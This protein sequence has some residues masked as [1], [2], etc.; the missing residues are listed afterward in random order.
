MT[1]VQLG[2][3]PPA[4]LEDKL[5][6]EKDYWLQKLA[7][8]LTVSGLPL[9]FIRPASFF[10]ERKVVA[11]EIYPDT[12]ARILAICGNSPSRVFTVLAAA[13][14]IC[15]FKY[16]GVVDIVIGTAIHEKYKVSAP[17]NKV[18]ALRDHISGAMTVREVLES[19][20]GTVSEAYSNQRYAFDRILEL[21][22]VE[23][24]SNRAPLFN[25]ALI[26]DDVNDRENIKHLKNDVTLAFSIQ[27][28]AI[29]GA[30][31]YNPSLFKKEAIKA[32]RDNYKTV[33]RA[34]LVQPDTAVSAL[35]LLSEE[36]K[37]E[38]IYDFNNTRQDYPK[39]KTAHQL[40]EEQA[41]ETPFSAALRW[42]DREL[43]YSGLNS[44]AHQL[45]GHL[46]S[47]GVK[48]GV[49]VGIYLEHS[50]DTVI[51]ILG[52]LKA[53]GAYVPL[54]TAHPPARL[55][56][57]IE[58]AR[59]PVLLT[60]SQ[61]ANR[62]PFGEFNIVRLDSDRLFVADSEK[63]NFASGVTAEDLAYIIYTSG[64]TG[65]PK[66]VMIRHASL[67][68]YIWWAKKSY[69]KGESLAFPL[70][71]SLAFDLTVTSIFTPL[72]T[73]NQIIVYREDGRE[74][75]LSRILRDNRVGVLK[76]TPS[77]LSLIKD[78]DNSQCNV[79]RLIVGGEALTA[80]VARQVRE[81]FAGDVEIFNEYGP[82]EATVGCMIHKFDPD[83]DDRASVPIGKPA[84]NA[85]IY[86]LDESLNPALENVIGE[87]YLSGDG[88]AKGYLNRSELTSERFI[89]NPFIPGTKMYKT[90][91][92]ARMLP[93]GTIEY[94]GRRDEQVKFHG[95][96]V[97][98]NEIRCALNR[99]PQV[100]ESVVFVNRDSNGGDVMIGYYVSRQE[101][102]PAQLRAFLSESLIEET[103]PNIF[104]HLKRLPL[105][106]N[107]K[108]NFRALPT[109]EEARQKLRRVFV[110][111]RTP[112]EELLANI[113]AEVLGTKQVGIYD[114]LFEL[115]G[116]SLLATRIISR[117]RKAFQVDLPMRIL[118][119][120]PTV[121]SL[122]QAIIQNQGRGDGERSPE[123]QSFSRANAPDL[124][125][126][127]DQL[128]DE[129]VDSLLSS[130]MSQESLATDEQQ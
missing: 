1:S 15:I 78:S 109:L 81:S 13:L 41:D 103:I 100:R 83:R 45:A 35:E 68:N 104:V 52:V 84:A 6:K 117:V 9:D 75:P 14:K 94:V 62:L 11:I 74:S 89:D 16:S 90:G 33:L 40:F 130:M 34:I 43:S 93:E 118:F 122:A 57:V 125:A 128:S 121:A 86:I 96:R 12:G 44:R 116:H 63:T 51:A 38:L 65:E 59:I 4:F 29:T 124:L 110:G 76:L 61:L 56:F 82:T 113:W 73:G 24:P 115:G 98:L 129:E 127:I 37:R 101:I 85:Q 92:L 126:G 50:F 25:V 54:D 108:I 60:H 64:S 7:G 19:V 119:Q 120:V 26:L 39:D 27:N 48:P 20:R 107:G 88:L 17:L 106:L 3:L 21:L 2:F 70:Y 66:G 32:F 28:D 102:E 30:L 77:H 46:R 114:N 72:I 105:T 112:T 111:P 80:N 18:L 97:E 42:D 8:E 22:G 99:H 67:V 47:L 79:K 69:L 53:G 31:E 23:H 87:L 71:S 91:D 5:K 10:P 55:A 36:K 58:D 49:P 95:Y 123:I